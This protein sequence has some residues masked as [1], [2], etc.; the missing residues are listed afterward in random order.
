MPLF[1]LEKVH[2][3]LALRVRAD[4]TWSPDCKFSTERRRS[5]FWRFAERLAD[6][7]SLGG[8]PIRSLWDLQMVGWTVTLSMT[9]IEW[10][11][12]DAPNRIGSERELAIN[13]AMTLARDANYP[14]DTIQRIREVTDPDPVMKEAVSAWLNP[15]E[16]SLDMLDREQ[17]LLASRH[18]SMVQRAKGDQS[19]IDFAAGIR[20]N[21]AQMRNLQPT[22]AA[23][24]DAKLY[25][26]WSLLSATTENNSRY[27]ISGVS[28]LEPMIGVGATEGFRLGLIAHWRPRAPWL[29][30]KR[31]TNDQNQICYW[32]AWA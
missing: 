1:A 4:L 8:Q 20:A 24:C 27:S 6:H 5:S 7:S 10:L 15:R 30:S 13:T 11:L 23:S 16:K 29:H 2:A 19:W 22:T 21:P 12:A 3:N 28:A 31:A 32:T 26:L 25:S 14:S 18:Q 17:R 9:D